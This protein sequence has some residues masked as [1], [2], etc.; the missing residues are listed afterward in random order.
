MVS[1]GPAHPAAHGVFR[2][3]FS[4][5]GEI[6]FSASPAQGLLFRATEALA[7]LKTSE[8]FSGYGARLDYVSF[9]IIESGLANGVRGSK[10]GQYFLRVN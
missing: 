3:V 7:E 2:L 9:F 1:F 4:V 8:S 6:I 5:E 10:K